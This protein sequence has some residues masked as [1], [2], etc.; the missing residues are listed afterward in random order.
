[1]ASRIG[2]TPTGP[3][4]AGAASASAPKERAACL[5]ALRRSAQRPGERSSE[6]VSSLVEGAQEAHNVRRMGVPRLPVLAQPV[7][8][9][10]A[11]NGVFMGWRDAQ[12]LACLCPSGYALQ[13]VG[14]KLCRR[15]HNRAK[16]VRCEKTVRRTYA[17]KPS[18]R[19]SSLARRGGR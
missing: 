14:V 19:R 13:G 18:A 16:R 5:Q 12:H 11:P 3:A 15:K 4:C 6:G 10:S 2:L 17:K 1:M 9:R 7:R 8:P